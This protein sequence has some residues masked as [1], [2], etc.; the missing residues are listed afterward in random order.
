MDTYA[1]GQLFCEFPILFYFVKYDVYE[2]YLPIY[3]IERY[4]IKYDTHILCQLQINYNNLL[5]H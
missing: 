5:N 2:N 4:H 1:R 3:F